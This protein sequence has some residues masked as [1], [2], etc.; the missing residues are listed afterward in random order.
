VVGIQRAE[1]VQRQH[2]LVSAGFAWVSFDGH[3]ICNL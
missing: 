1:Q 2:V 3:P